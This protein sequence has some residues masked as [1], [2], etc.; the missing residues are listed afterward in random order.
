MNVQLKKGV[1]DMCVLSLLIQGECY[2]YELVNKVSTHISISEG[3]MYPVLKRLSAEKCLESYVKESREGPPR[4]Y[5][6]ITDEGCQRLKELHL[7]WKQF[8]KSINQLMGEEC[9]EVE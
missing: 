9:E 7:E 4:K 3:T 5:Y 6:K 2:G 1:L 8:Y